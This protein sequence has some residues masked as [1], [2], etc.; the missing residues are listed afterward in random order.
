[1]TKEELVKIIDVIRAN[2][3][4]MNLPR[5]KQ[6][7]LYDSWWRYIGEFEYEEVMAVVD[8]AILA[9]SWSPRIG[10]VVRSVLDRRSG[11][12][13]PPA[14]EDAFLEVEAMMQAVSQGLPSDITPHPLVAKALSS[15]RQRT[16][17]RVTKKAFEEEYRAVLLEHYRQ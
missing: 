8:D 3:N 17:N 1:M 16:G 7:A 13:S 5:D 12:K 2:W 10:W 11:E 4:M 6:R 14:E 9:D 15:L